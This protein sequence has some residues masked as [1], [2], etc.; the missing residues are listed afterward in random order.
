MPFFFCECKC[1]HTKKH[2]VLFHSHPSCIPSFTRRNNDFSFFFELY[3]LGLSPSHISVDE[4]HKCVIT[5]WISQKISKR[6][7]TQFNNVVWKTSIFSKPKKTS[8]LPYCLLSSCR[9]K[10]SK[11]INFLSFYHFLLTSQ[12]FRVDLKVRSGKSS[13]FVVK[14][15]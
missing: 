7:S 3:F 10:L 11:I 5:K 6:I 1:F 13:K 15:V 4:I 12:C 2:K 14:C 8:L 9:Q